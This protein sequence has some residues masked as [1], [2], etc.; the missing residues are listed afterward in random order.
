MQNEQT[1]K[2]IETVFFGKNFRKTSK[3][4]LKIFYCIPMMLVLCLK[5]GIRIE[6]YQYMDMFV[7]L[8]VDSA[9]ACMLRAYFIM[10]KL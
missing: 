8:N 7:C 6:T 3:T 10:F 1:Y 5:K 4:K 9:T 2:N